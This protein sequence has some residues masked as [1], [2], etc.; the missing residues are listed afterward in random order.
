M[1]KR[2]MENLDGRDEDFLNRLRLVDMDVLARNIDPEHLYQEA[3]DIDVREM[4][5]ATERGPGEYEGIPDC[6]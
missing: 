3:L 2:Q 5:H 4:T 6:E 1:H